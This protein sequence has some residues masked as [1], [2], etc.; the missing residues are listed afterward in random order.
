MFVME[1]SIYSE[2]PLI[3]TTLGI[4]PS[5]LKEVTFQGMFCIYNMAALEI[6][7]VTFQRAR[8][9]GVHCTYM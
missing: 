7:V 9:A 4:E 8:I 2:L 3:P 5:G 1:E 6:E